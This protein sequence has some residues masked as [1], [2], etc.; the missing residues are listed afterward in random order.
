[1]VSRYYGFPVCIVF[2]FHPPEKRWIEVL[3]YN[4]E[5]IK[6]LCGQNANFSANLAVYIQTTR[7]KGLNI[8]SEN[9]TVLCF[10][11]YTKG[12]C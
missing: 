4:M 9:Y 3:L 6:S 5:H 2:V 7:F 1:M 11:Q 12:Q 8:N 10:Y